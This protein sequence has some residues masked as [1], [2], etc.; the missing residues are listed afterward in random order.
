MKKHLFNDYKWKENLC[1]AGVFGGENSGITNKTK[2]IFLECAYF[3]PT[4][5][6]KTAKDLGL[7]TDASFRFERGIDSSSLTDSIK[8]AA[9]LIQELTKGKISMPLKCVG[10]KLDDFKTVNFNPNKAR[11]LIGTDISDELIKQI[12]NELEIDICSSENENWEL[13]VPSY[14]VDVNRHADVVEEVLRIYGFNKI[15]IPS[16]LNTSILPLRNLILKKSKKTFL[17]CLFQRDTL[18]S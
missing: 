16:K 18:R 3:D 11:S 6:R 14:R 8:R 9:L 4:C 17:I 5:I 7:N 2:N 1:I 15:E 13:N 12:L 10:S